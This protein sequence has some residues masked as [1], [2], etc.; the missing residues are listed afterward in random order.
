MQ[1]NNL[2]FS[3]IEVLVWIFIFRL[4]LTAVFNLIL[5]TLRL[6][7]YSRNSIIASNLAREGLEI[8]KNIRDSNYIHTYRWDKLPWVD[9]EKTFWDWT[10]YRVENNI[11]NIIWENTLM[12]EIVDFWEWEEEL[13]NKMENYRLCISEKNI[14]TYDCSFPN[15]KTN[16]YRYI[17]FDKVEYNDDFWSTQEIEDAYEVTSKVIWFSRWYHSTEQKTIMT[18]FLRL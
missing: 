10:Y 17:K 7:D 14:Y 4:G 11:D 6:D 16:F 1:K 2:W 18:D 15:T 13:T 12:S 3:M 8:V 9:F 5:S